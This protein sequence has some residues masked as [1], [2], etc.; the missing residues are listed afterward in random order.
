MTNVVEFSGGEKPV[1][2]LIGPFSYYQVVIEGRAIPRLTGYKGE[3]KTWLRLDNRFGIEVPNDLAY[4]VA[5]MLAN[6]LAI[7]EGFAFL[8]SETK[9]RPFAPKS[10]ELGERT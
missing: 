2:F 1:D 9:E 4:Q 3:T 5:W 6:A 10:M 7:G 8:G